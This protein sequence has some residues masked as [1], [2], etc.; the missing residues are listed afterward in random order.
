MAVIK[1]ALL[2]RRAGMLLSLLELTTTPPRHVYSHVCLWFKIYPN[3][4]YFGYNEIDSNSKKIFTAR[5]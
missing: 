4:V 3:S 5:S 2:G 1:L